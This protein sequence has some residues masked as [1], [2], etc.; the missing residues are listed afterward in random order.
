ML[1]SLVILVVSLMSVPAVNASVRRDN[2]IKIW[3]NGYSHV[4]VSFMNSC[5]ASVPASVI[6]DD[7]T[8]RSRYNT[9][10]SS[11]SGVT[12]PV[13]RARLSTQC[14]ANARSP[15]FLTAYQQQLRYRSCLS[16][17]R[18]VVRRGH[19][20]NHRVRTT[21]HVGSSR[22]VNSVRHATYKPVRKRTTVSRTVK[23]NV[24]RRNSSV[25]SRRSRGSQSRSSSHNS[26]RRR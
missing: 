2:H 20:Y 13:T 18:V 26:R 25:N 16:T 4:P 17:Y 1:R 12:C 19:I 24:R 8:V 11:Y 9:C 23:H 15:I 22:N 21:A 10:M 14:M 7:Y 3:S 6:P 5:Y